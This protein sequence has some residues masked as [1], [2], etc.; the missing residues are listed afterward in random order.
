MYMGFEWDDGNTEHV[1]EHQIHPDEAEQA[2][3]DPPRA[4]CSGLRQ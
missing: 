3:D 2:I 1:A 4:E